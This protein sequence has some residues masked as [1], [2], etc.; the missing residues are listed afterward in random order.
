MIISKFME[1]L[2]YNLMQNRKTLNEATAWKYIKFLYQLNNNEKFNS[3]V[4]LK[5]IDGVKESIKHYS[6]NYQNSFIT[7]ICAILALYKDNK[8]YNA[9]YTKYYDIL[10]EYDEKRRALDESHEMSEKQ[11]SA[12]LSF[13]DVKAIHQDLKNNVDKF[14]SKPNITEN[15]YNELFNYLLLSLFILSAPRRNQDYQE[16]QILGK[17]NEEINDDTKNYLD[18]STHRFIFNKYKTAKHMGRQ[19][20]DISPELFDIINLYIKHHPAKPKGRISKNWNFPFLVKHNGERLTQINAITRAFN[21]IFKK[22]IGASMLRHIFIT[23]KFGK[24]LEEM[25]DTA[26]DMGHTIEQQRAYIKK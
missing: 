13:D 21:K 7:A 18:L 12:W 11:K 15:Q 9:L 19:I 8:T 22:P 23:A 25:E 10:K 20:I 14:I 24:E 5:N 1:N 17:Y 3:L 16:M 26:E 6:E 2:H 4:F